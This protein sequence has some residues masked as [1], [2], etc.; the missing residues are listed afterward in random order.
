MA[1]ATAAAPQFQQIT[2]R[3]QDGLAIVTL[4]RPRVANAISRR[5]TRELDRAFDDACLDDRVGC[6]VLLAA[7]KHFSSGH[8][9]G[10][11]EHFA[12]KEFPQELDRRPRGSYL[13]WYENDLQ[14]CSRW[15]R[16]RKPV[17]C[18]VQGLCVYHATAVVAC[19]DVIVAADN[20]KYMPSLL[21]VNLFPWAAG[22]QVHKIKEIMLTQRFVLAPEALEVFI[23]PS[24]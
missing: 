15:R 24:L 5:M 19:A 18:A 9:L 16:L 12:D 1:N 8:D 6:I 14:A 21:E 4:N 3:V 7:G 22:L 20:L 17:V 10:T 2:Y 23:S 13:K 11:P